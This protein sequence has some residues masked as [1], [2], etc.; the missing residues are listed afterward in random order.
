MCFICKIL[1]QTISGVTSNSAF[2]NSGLSWMIKKWINWGVSNHPKASP[3]Q[4]IFWKPQSAV[5]DHNNFMK[6]IGSIFFILNHLGKFYWRTFLYFCGFLNFFFTSENL[7]FGFS[8][9]KT[10]LYAHL[11]ALLYK[12]TFIDK[13]NKILLKI[14]KWHK[15]HFSCKLIKKNNK[16]FGQKFFSVL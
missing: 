6:Q 5:M 1:I 9:I 13:T 7:V 2:C 11:N 8:S 14:F 4:I 16:T 12:I 15:T 3:G 10:V